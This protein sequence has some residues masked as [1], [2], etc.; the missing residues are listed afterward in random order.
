MSLARGGEDVLGDLL[1]VELLVELARAAELRDPLVDRDRAHLRRPRGDDPLPADAAV[2]DPGDLLDPARQHAARARV[3]PGHP[4]AREA[5][6]V[7]QHPDPA[8]V[9]QIADRAGEQ[10]D[11]DQVDGVVVHAAASVARAPWP[12]RR[13]DRAQAAGGGGR[14]AERDRPPGPGRRSSKKSTLET[15]AANG[16]ASDVGDDHEP[17]SRRRRRRSRRRSRRR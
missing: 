10:R 11:R 4:E 2:R 13:C 14:G 1:G 6:R 3:R 7:E 16:A 15:S 9:G 8:P 12:A 17:R 5:D